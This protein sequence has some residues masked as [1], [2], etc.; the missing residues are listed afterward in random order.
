M[1]ESAE[2]LFSAGPV[3]GEVDLRWRG[4]SLSWCELAKGPVRPRGVVVPHVLDQHPAQM[5]L[6]DDQQPVQ[7]LAAQGAD[8]PFADGAGSGRLRWDQ[9]NPDAFR[10]E[11]GVEGVGELACAV[12]DQEL[13]WSRACA[14]VRQDVT[15][16]SC[17]PCAVGF[18]G[19]A[20]QVNAAGAVLD[21]DQGVDAPQEHRVHVY[22]IG[23]EDAA[24]LDGQELAAAIGWPSLTSSPC[25]RRCP[26][27]GLSVAMR[28]TS[29]RIAAAVDGRP[30]RRRFV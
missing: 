30:G 8:D 11:Y 18:R 14:D 17:R 16:C 10:G 28:I 19:D 15:R 9:E 12:P 26:Q 6:I 3:L 5:V 13:D 21:D 1:C 20:G 22:E 27:A 24:G 25:T 29:L 2:D 7:E 4:V 23:R